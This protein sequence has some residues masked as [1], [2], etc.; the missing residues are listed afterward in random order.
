ME[1]SIPQLLVSLDGKEIDSAG[2][3]KERRRPELLELFAEHVYGRQPVS[4]PQWMIFAAAAQELC[5]DGKA[6]RKNIDIHFVGDGEGESGGQG[7]IRLT[8]YVPA[9]TGGAEKKR[10]PV[11]LLLD[12]GRLSA[13]RE[14]ESPSTPF[15]PVEQII[16]SGYGTAMIAAEDIDPDAHDGFRNGVHGLFDPND[17]PRAGD[18]WGT[19][20]AWAW[21]L[22]RAMDY[23][24]TD[25]D[26]DSARVAVIG[27]SRG[28]K[29]A[30][31]AGALDERFAMVVSNESGC[32][33]AAISRGKVGERVHQINTAFPH[34]FADNYKRYNEREEELPV[35]QHMLLAMIAPR[36]LYV[37]SAAEDEW[38]DPASEYLS[39]QLAEPAYR[40][41]GL[42]GL[43][44]A[45]FPE[46]DS[47]LHAERCGYHIRAGRHDLNEVDWTYVLAFAEGRL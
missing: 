12:H 27:H 29:T 15:W 41:H 10:W 35:D 24:E 36:L 23:L 19:I 46:L 44:A 40:L 45:P 34:W 13:V 37:S 11:F 26:V 3:W 38:A 33:G 9:D 22:S 7:R 4:R 6:V 14:G 39:L 17:R 8:L 43:A 16:D 47:P 20:S 42:G 32:T 30:L 2:E 18:A 21:G 1:R 25:P 28:G 5:L 31:W